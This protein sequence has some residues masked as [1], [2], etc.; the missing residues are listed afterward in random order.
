MYNEISF[1]NPNVNLD[2]YCKPLLLRSLSFYLNGC[3]LNGLEDLIG[4]FEDS[5]LKVEDADIM[6]LI[7]FIS[8]I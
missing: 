1:I 2:Y 3:K 7:M 8:L 4:S 6:K 5:D